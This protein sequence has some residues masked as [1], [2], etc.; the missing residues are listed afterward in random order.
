MQ[1]DSERQGMVP[2]LSGLRVGAC[3]RGGGGPAYKR[4]VVGVRATDPLTLAT[5]AIVLLAAAICGLLLP[6]QA[7]HTSGSSKGGSAFQKRENRRELVIGLTRLV[8]R[9]IVFA[10]LSICGESPAERPR[11]QAKTPV[12]P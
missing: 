12:L 11:R 8:V 6:G 4:A 10:P 7:S 9:N 5:V 3:R 2:V 1:R